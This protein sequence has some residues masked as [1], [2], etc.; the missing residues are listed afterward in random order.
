MGIWGRSPLVKGSGGSCKLV[1]EIPFH[2]V[3]FSK[4]LYFNTIYDANQFIYH[5]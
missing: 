3:K 1:Q 4:F 2:I 5:C